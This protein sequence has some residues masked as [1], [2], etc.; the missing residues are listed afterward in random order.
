MSLGN[1]PD[2]WGEGRVWPDEADEV[3]NRGLAAVVSILAATGV[4]LLP[5]A[6]EEGV[7]ADRILFGQSA[8]LTGPAAELGLEMQR[9]ILGAGS[10]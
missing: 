1:E 6:A 7:A 2:P 8:A 10:S 4:W 9:G 3:I 5:A